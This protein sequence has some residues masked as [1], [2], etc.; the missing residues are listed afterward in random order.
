MLQEHIKPAL[1]ITSDIPNV[2]VA[3]R[4]PNDAGIVYIG[5]EVAPDI[6]VESCSKGEN[7]NLP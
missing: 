7:A 1:K 5:A 4:K 6:L 2:L 3:L